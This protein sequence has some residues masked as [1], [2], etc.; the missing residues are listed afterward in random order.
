MNCY[1][2]RDKEATGG[3]VGCGHLICAECKAMLGE[4]SYCKACA[5][6]L[7]TG[8]RGTET[9]V[10][11]NLTVGLDALGDS[12]SRF[13]S[14]RRQKTASPTREDL[15]NLFDGRLGRLHYFL[16]CTII[17]GT[18]LLFVL[19]HFDEYLSFLFTVLTLPIAVRR[20]HDVGLPGFLTPIGW[21]SYLGGV[22]IIVA[23]IFNLC[24]YVVPGSKHANKYGEPPRPG[25][26]FLDAVLGRRAEGQ[27]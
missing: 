11:E 10:P 13:P 26:R 9:A 1:Y 23:V 22:F 24:L 14:V 5:D 17:L 21:L 12:A 27:R 3:C 4:K 15:R 25:L 8:M 18:G 19:I 7:A 2:H 6:R 16:G 20:L